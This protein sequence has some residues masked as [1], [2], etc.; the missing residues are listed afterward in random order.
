MV[1]TA[2]TT[3]PFESCSNDPIGYEGS[4]WN[5]FEY[6]NG[7]VPIQLDPSGLLFG[8]SYGKYCGLKTNGGGK[9]ANDAL[10]RACKKHDECIPTWR[11]CNL[12]TI[13]T[14]NDDLCHDAREARETGCAQSYPGDQA[15]IDA[16]EN[17]AFKV[18]MIMCLFSNNPR[19][20]DV[21]FYPL[22]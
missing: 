1:A 10:D 2:P 22:M 11:S 4:K 19:S 8:F 21:P 17:A 6:V 13:V 12:Y 5:L 7:A 3:L 9:P 18:M 15:K 20:P 16:C 14:C